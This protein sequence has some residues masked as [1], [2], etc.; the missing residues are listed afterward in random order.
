M[1]KETIVRLRDDI[2]GELVEEGKGESIR[3]SFNGKT[4]EIDLD[5]KNAKKFHETMKF[6]TDHATEVGDEV[7]AATL[8]RRRSSGGAKSSNKTDPELLNAIREW[9]RANGHT[10]A[11]R[12]RIKGE[13]VEAYHAANK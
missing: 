10:V 8:L 4:Y 2:T 9:A 13:I 1:A 5:D 11:D 3:F 7:P 12:G 6:Y